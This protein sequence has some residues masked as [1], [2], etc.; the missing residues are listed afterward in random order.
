MRFRFCLLIPV[1]LQLFLF[2]CK[3]EKVVVHDLDQIVQEGELNV[4]TLNVSTSYFIYREDTMGYNY[5]MARNFCESIGVKLNVIVA[6]NEKRLLELLHKGIGDVVAYPIFVTNEMKDSVIYCGPQ[7]INHQVLVQRANKGD[8]ILTSQDQLIGKTVYTVKDSKYYERINHFNDELGGGIDIKCI[9]RD[10]VTTEDL[11][12]MVSA[13]QIRYTLSDN[14]LAKLNKTYYNN[15]NISLPMSFDQRSLW[16]V[17]HNS[18]L[19]AEALNKWV[20]KYDKTPTFKAVVKKYFELSKQPLAA[21]YELPKGLPKGAI[22]PYDDLFKKYAKKT[23]YSWELLAAISYNESRFQNN[24]TSWAGAAGIMGLMPRTAKSLGLS[25]TDRMDPDLSIGAGVQL[26]N[27]L[28]VIFKRV[29]D[30][31]ERIKFILAAYNGG[32]GH[33]RD[34][35]RLATKYGMNPYKWDGNV[36]KFVLLKSNPEYYEDPICRNGYFRGVETVKYVDNV[37]K[38][39]EHFTNGK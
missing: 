19:L 14:V 34:A 8:T 16:V 20:E 30:K 27:R 36:R 33:I 11:I 7:Q 10:T 22:S 5:D 26:L 18:P 28:D 23:N 1:I 13:G 37:L 21:H 35:M 38:T 17:R 32:D 31:N 4:L 6:E 12:E 24:L 9:D 29:D 25:S 3:K 2:S 39:A 15:I